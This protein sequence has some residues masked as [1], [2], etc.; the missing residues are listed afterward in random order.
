ME[1]IFLT[2]K[3]FG[4]RSRQISDFINSSNNYQNQQSE[5]WIGEWMKLREC[6]DEMVIATKFTL[7]YRMG[8]TDAILCNTAGNSAK[9]LHVSVEASLR[10]LQTTYIDL[11]RFVYY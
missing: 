7:P 9:S 11:V 3:S 8:D 5:I 2:R 6:R 1:A 4:A 10:K